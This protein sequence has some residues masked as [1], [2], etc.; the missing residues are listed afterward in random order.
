MNKKVVKQVYRV[1]RDGRKDKSS[2]LDSNNEKPINVLETSATISEKMKQLCTDNLDVESEQKKLKVP[3]VKDKLLQFTRESQPR[4]PLGLSNWE[5]KKLQRLSAQELKEKNMAWVPKGSVQTQDNNDGAQ[6]KGATEAKLNKGARRKLP[7]QRFLP[8]HQNYWL[9]H[10]P[11]AFP[12]P[13]MPNSW[14]SSLGMFEYPPCSYFY[15]P[16]EL[17]EAPYHGG[18]LPNYYAL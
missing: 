12:L 10:H 18:L 6:V 8:Y 3:K 11:Y 13:L 9:F 4:Y 14:S 15:P 17:H 5:K 16:F 7:S 2:V 1:K